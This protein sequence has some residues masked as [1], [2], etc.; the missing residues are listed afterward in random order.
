M[1]T[2][3]D[4]NDCDGIAELVL[5]KRRAKAM[6]AHY[7]R[8]F[9]NLGYPEYDDWSD[10]RARE[11]VYETVLELRDELADWADAEERT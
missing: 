10:Q 8:Y 4:W 9:D 5:A 2:Q 1:K 11:F 7:L 3:L 6:L